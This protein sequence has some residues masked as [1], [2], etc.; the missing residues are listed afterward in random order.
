ML[1]EVDAHVFFGYRSFVDWA[2]ENYGEGGLLPDDVRIVIADKGFIDR[3]KTVYSINRQ[4]GALGAFVENP[5][6]N[7]R[8]EIPE[9]IRGVP[10]SVLELGQDEEDFS[11]KS[12]AAGY[13]E[14]LGQWPKRDFRPHPK[15]DRGS[16]KRPLEVDFA[17]AGLVVGLNTSALVAA[18]MAG[19][20]VEAFGAH[21]V[22]RGINE[23][24][25]ERLSWLRS[26]EWDRRDPA[27]GPAIAA[28]LADPET[29]LAMPEGTPQTRT[30]RKASRK[31][32]AS[33]RSRGSRQARG[34][35]SGKSGEG[36]GEHAET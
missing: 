8:F 12:D 5:Q 28:A 35:Q 2:I 23:C 9:L 19:L 18:S 29:A 16:L 7:L 6:A 14:W 21:S 30:A 1:E 33:K 36:T 31:K 27:A 25:D 24:R 20:Q 15:V 17:G 13:A 22:A 34:S 26:I 10:R 32:P 11:F 4:W 3:R